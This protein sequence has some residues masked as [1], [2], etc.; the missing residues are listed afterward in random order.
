MKKLLALILAAAMLT[1]CG[2]TSTGEGPAAPA[3]LP[4]ESATT[5][6]AQYDSRFGS[7]TKIV[8][9]DSGILVD[10]GEETETVYT[11]RDIIY[12]ED[13][14]A[15][16]SGNPYGE[17]EVW[18]R[19][20][21]EEAAAHTVVNITAPGA[22][23]VSGKLAAGQIRVDLGEDAYEDPNAV[24]ELILQDAD[25]TCTVAPVILFLNTYEC[26]GDWSAET[27]SPN[28]DTAAAGANLI[29]E[30]E[31]ILNGSHVARIF[32]DKDGEKKLWKQDGAIYSY[33]SMNVSGSGSLNLTADNEG[34]GTELHL[35]INGGNI[36][37]DSGNDGINTKPPMY[38]MPLLMVAAPITA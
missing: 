14:D 36:R 10:G 25:I 18:E 21:T 32:K 19:H 31:N 24:V 2:S 5:P 22:Y 6:D 23:R 3:E 15:Y 1:G 34:L 9:S 8:L 11:S 17:G 28:V 37:I 29:L 4:A 26:D 30:G 7:E 38:A 20:S 12:Y 13:R 27:A 16:E 35:T 33:M